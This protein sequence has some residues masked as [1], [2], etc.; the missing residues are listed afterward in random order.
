MYADLSHVAALELNRQASSKVTAQHLQVELEVAEDD[1]A[2]KDREAQRGQVEVIDVLGREAGDERADRVLQ[3]HADT[4]Q[5]REIL[6][7]LFSTTAKNVT[8]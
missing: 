8:A 1:V 6:T 3:H 5:R 4:H 2:T 7:V